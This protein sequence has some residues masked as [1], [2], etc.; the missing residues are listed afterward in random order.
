MSTNQ[1]YVPKDTLL[2]IF[3]P[4]YFIDLLKLYNNPSLYVGFE[5]PNTPENTEFKV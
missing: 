5:S 2:K 4:Y 3:Q 1:V